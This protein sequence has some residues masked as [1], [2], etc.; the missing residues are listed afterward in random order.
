MNRPVVVYPGLP[1][2]HLVAEANERASTATTVCGRVVTNT[3]TRWA[4]FSFARGAAWLTTEQEIGK[5]K[6]VRLCKLCDREPEGR[7]S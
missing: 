6:D 2:F 1:I 4:D 7:S 3:S 5:V